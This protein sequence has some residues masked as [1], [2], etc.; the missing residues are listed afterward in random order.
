MASTVSVRFIQGGG[1]NG[2]VDS[3]TALSEENLTSSGSSVA[4]TI[5]A[6]GATDEIVVIYPLTENQRVAFGPSPTAATSAGP[7][8]YAGM[9]NAFRNVASGDKVAVITAT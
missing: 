4:T 5:T 8:A 3:A 6:S 7:I 2:P 9:P 1:P